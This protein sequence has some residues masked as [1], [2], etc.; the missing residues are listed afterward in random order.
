M[1]LVR[2][3]A[4]YVERAVHFDRMAAVETDSKLKQSVE[5]QA[6]AYRKLAEKRAIEIKLAPIN[7]PAVIPPKKGG[8]P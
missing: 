7:L 1:T 8:P 2:M 5:Q 6:A 3:I 4:E